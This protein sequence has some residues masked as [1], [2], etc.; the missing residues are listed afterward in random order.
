MW[1][2]F[3]ALR[4][5]SG[6]SATPCAVAVAA[7]QLRSLGRGAWTFGAGLRQTCGHTSSL[8][9]AAPLGVALNRSRGRCQKSIEPGIGVTFAPHFPGIGSIAVSLFWSNTEGRGDDQC[10]SDHTS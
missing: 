4:E 9:L 8:S 2:S 7:A 5:L 10:G 1:F 3:Q 6:R